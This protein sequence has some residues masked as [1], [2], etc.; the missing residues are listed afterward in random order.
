MNIYY[1]MKQL[2]NVVMSSSGAASGAG[3]GTNYL[4]DSDDLSSSVG[5]STD[6]LTGILY[7]L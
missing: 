1:L 3:H 6:L 5:G 2:N 7:H 4:K